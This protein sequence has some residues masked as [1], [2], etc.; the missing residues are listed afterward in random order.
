MP[1]SPVNPAWNFMM[2]PRHA[3]KTKSRWY[4]NDEFRS[5]LPRL[6]SDLRRAAIHEQFDSGDKARVVRGQENRRFGNFIRATHA[7]HRDAGDD[8]GDGL[9]GK[10][11]QDRR[12]DRAGTND[13]G[14]DLAILELQ[15]PSADKGTD[16]CLAGT[17]NAKCGN[18]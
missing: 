14:A 5:T 8:L 15:R 9:L 2:A 6:R 7:A 17:V 16:G 10:R 3:C 11:C 4:V 13:I 1:S 12:I 18:P